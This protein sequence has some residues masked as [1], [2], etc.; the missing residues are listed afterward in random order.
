MGTGWSVKRG[1]VQ[2]VPNRTAVALEPG[3]LWIGGC[4]CHAPD[5]QAYDLLRGF[6]A[7]R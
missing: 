6:E 5:R 7:M 1:R 3:S 4:L 2:A